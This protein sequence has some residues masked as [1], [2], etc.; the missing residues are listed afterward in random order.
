MD[1]LY[2]IENDVNFSEKAQENA[3]ELRDTLLDP[4]FVSLMKIQEE[5]LS[6]ASFESL[7][8]QQEGQSPIGILINRVNTDKNTF[9]IL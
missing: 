6:L 5:V 4:G 2:E 9:E 8:Y 7:H 1:H 3:K